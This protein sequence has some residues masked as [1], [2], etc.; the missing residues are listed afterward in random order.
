M[1]NCVIVVGVW[2]VGDS[3]LARARPALAD[4]LGSMGPVEWRVKGGWKWRHYRPAID[5]LIANS[6]RQ[7]RILVLHLGSNDLGV[8]TGRELFEQIMEQLLYTRLRLP[9]TRLLWSNMLPR[10]CWR[11]A[12]DIKCVELGRKKLNRRVANLM[13]T[14]DGEVIRNDFIYPGVD[15]YI[16]DG[17]HLTPVGLHI[18]CD[19]IRC[20]IS[21]S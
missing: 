1:T 8:T 19:D 12:R 21:S 2:V 4:T 20:S 14:I 7:P 13:R 16:S 15:H 6:A 3:Y 9:H 11:Y 17:V 5:D 18:F 10:C